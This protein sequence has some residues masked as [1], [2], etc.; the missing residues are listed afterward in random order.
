M[1]LSPVL[2]FHSEAKNEITKKGKGRA[3][4]TVPFDGDPSRRENRN[5][6]Q[7]YFVIFPYLR[8][9][10]CVQQYD[11]TVNLLVHEKNECYLVIKLHVRCSP[12]FVNQ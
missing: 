8:H 11:A 9:T 4:G 3:Q 7:Q 6:K 12:S 5:R 2:A 10:Q 1:W